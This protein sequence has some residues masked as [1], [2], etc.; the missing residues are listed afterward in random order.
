MG[1]L[2]VQWIHVLRKHGELNS[3]IQKMKQTLQDPGLVYYCPDEENYQ[4]CKYFQRTPVT[5]KYLPLVVKHLNGDGFIITAFFISVSK[6][7]K[8]GKVIVYGQ[9][10]VHEL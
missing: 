7:R 4:Y 8:T 1:S 6:M 2:N 10:D 5:E 3:Q 9:E